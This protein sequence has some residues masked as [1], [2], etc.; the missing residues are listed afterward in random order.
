MTRP[1]FFVLVLVLALFPMTLLAQEQ[2]PP[3]E[4]QQ[5]PEKPKTTEEIV[6]T[7]RHVEETVQEAPISVAAPTEQQLRDRGAETLEDVS[8]NVAGFNVQNAGPGQSQVGMRGVSAGRII[9]DQPGVKE[10]VGIYLDESV[11][12]LSLFTPDLDL[13]DVS[14]IEVLRGPQ[15]TLFGSGSLAGTVRYITNQPTLGENNSVAEITASSM[16]GGSFGGALKAATNAALGENVAMRAVG[17]YTRYEGFIDAVQPNLSVDEGVNTGERKGARLAFLFKPNDKLSI[18]PR[19]LIQNVDMDGWNRID[20]FNILANPYTTTRPKVSLDDRRQFTQFKEPYTDEFRLVDLNIGYDLGFAALT[21]ISSYSDRDI[22][23]V[24]DATALTAS[25]TGGSFG[26]P[27]NIYTI[28]APLSDATEARSLTQEVRL[29]SKGESRW[30]WV[31]GAFYS[32][33]NR[34]YGQN[35]PVLG[36]EDGCRV[37][38]CGPLSGLSTAG[39]KIALKDELYKSDLHYDF[40]QLAVFGE[41]TFAVNDRL[42][43]TGGL[44]WYNFE[45]DRTQVFDGIFSDP[46]DSVGSVS[47][48]GFAPRVILSYKLNDNTR[49]NAQVSKG[50][51]LG[52]LND[53]LNRPLCTPQDLAIYDG[54]G[55]WEDE[56]LWDYEAGIKSTIGGGRGTFNASAYYNDIEDLQAT[57]TAGSCSSRIIVNVPKARTAGIEAEFEFAPNDSFDFAVSGNYNNSELRSDFRSS[58]GG[59]VA[60]I[61]AGNRLPSV[62]EFQMA[63]A[64]TYHFPLR[65]GMA[66]YLTGVYQHVGDRYT[67]VSDQE[68]GFGTVDISAFGGDIGGPYTQ[69]VITFDPLMPAYDVVNVRLGVLRGQWDVAFFINNITDERAFLALDIERGSRARVSYMTNTPRTFG[70]STR[71]NF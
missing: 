43:I 15:G 48:D 69:N 66:G 34:D 42:D 4:Q 7:A 5:E 39:S 1:V 70:V 19:V 6:V 63:A 47:A 67:Q 21:A 28:D 40:N 44:R 14:R 17:Y 49:L 71:V 56:T 13:F 29:S 30:Q 33:S 60:G 3:Q 10:Q 27:Q 64:A 55:T 25:I 41:A 50:F 31:A 12:S 52:G 20:T 24:R 68:V 2:Q 16:D 61:Q 23:V 46:N 35:L 11:I 22:L 32:D 8:V 18:T 58:T 45:E 53:P 65:S 9:R 51:R 54:R 37:A 36:F 59:I 57:V 26:A 62:P 38:N